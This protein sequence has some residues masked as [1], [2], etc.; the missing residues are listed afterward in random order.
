MRVL[1]IL[2]SGIFGG[3]QRHTQCLA[4]CLK[5]VCGVAVCIVGKSEP[6][7]SQMRAAG[8]HVYALDCRNG[9]DWR[10][11]H[12]FDRVLREFQPDVIHGQVLPAFC[13]LWLRIRNVKIPVIQSV[14]MPVNARPPLRR[15]IVGYFSN[16][17]IDYRLAVSAATW[18]TCVR[19]LP[20][21]RGEVFYNPIIIS[22]VVGRSYEITKR[23]IVGMVG[24]MAPEKDWASFGALAKRLPDVDFRGIGV[25]AEEAEMKLG[26]NASGVRWMGPQPNGRN[27]IRAMD[28]FTLTS[29]SEEMP[30]VVLEC[31]AERTPICGFIPRGG[32]KEILAFS[33]GALKEAFLEDRDCGKLAA[34]VRRVLGDEDFRRRLVEDGWQIVTRHFDAMKNSRGRLME[35]YR[36]LTKK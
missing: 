16:C 8:I 2:D 6:L 10:C 20:G 30:T 5:D 14:H 9:H 3:I 12:R 18:D 34:V 28:L 22:S 35:I 36:E 13:S 23:P 25:T 19:A 33:N 15:R 1:Y 21:V 26:E 32:L 27:C 29:A 24:R 7:A 11:F 17:R 4:S 31:F